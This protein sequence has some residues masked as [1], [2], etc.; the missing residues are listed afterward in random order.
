MGS[1][2]QEKLQTGHEGARR[3]AEIKTNKQTNDYLKEVGCVYSIQEETGGLGEKP[4]ES[5]KN[6]LRDEKFKMQNY[7]NTI[8]GKAAL[9]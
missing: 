8:V 4:N 2:T 9:I 1:P 6:V 3:H 5:D 7:K